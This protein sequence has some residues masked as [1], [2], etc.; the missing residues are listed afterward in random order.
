MKKTMN[1]IIVTVEQVSV[2]LGVTERH[3]HNLCKKDL[4]H[5]KVRN[6]LRFDLEDVR[7]YKEKFQ[8]KGS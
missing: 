5:I 3:V 2:I 7:A 8:K 6:E 4:A 1:T